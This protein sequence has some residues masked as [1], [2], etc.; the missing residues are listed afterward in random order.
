MSLYGH[1]HGG[2]VAVRYASTYPHHLDALVIDGTPSRHVELP[3]HIEQIEQMFADWERSGRDYVQRLFAE[4]FE[5][6]R[7][8]SSRMNGRPSICPRT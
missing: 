1:S 7:V 6:A 8:T 4:R 5:G 3:E 2:I